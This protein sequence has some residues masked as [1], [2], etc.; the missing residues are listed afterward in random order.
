MTNSPFLNLDEIEAPV[1]KSVQIAGKKYAMKPVSVS[2]YVRSIKLM[3]GVDENKDPEKVIDIMVETIMIAFPEIEEQ[4]VRD[5]SMDKLRAL[6]EFLNS[7]AEEE[8][9]AGNE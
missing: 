6:T 4:T 2:D 8:A 5:L 1:V 9:K 7:E 3:D